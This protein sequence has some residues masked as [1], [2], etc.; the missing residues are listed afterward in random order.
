M[1]CTTA[2]YDKRD[3][4][5]SCAAHMAAGVVAL[6]VG[7]ECTRCGRRAERHCWRSTRGRKAPSESAP[8][9]QMQ[10]KQAQGHRQEEHRRARRNV[11]GRDCTKRMDEKYEGVENYVN[12]P[13]VE[14]KK[15]MR[16]DR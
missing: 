11:H 8:A 10:L 6:A 14:T 5:H 13:L 1:P 4:F 9:Q 2:V 3:A 7:D 12:Y 16:E 15:G